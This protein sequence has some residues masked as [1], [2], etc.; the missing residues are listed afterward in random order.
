M[1]RRGIPWAGSELVSGHTMESKF[2]MSS[3]VFCSGAG[4]TV[5][6]R[7]VCE[8]ECAGELNHRSRGQWHM[9][10]FAWFSW[11]PPPESSAAGAGIGNVGCELI[12]GSAQPRSWPSVQIDSEIHLEACCAMTA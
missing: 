1:V 2:G 4:V 9:C 5:G 10:S 3:F 12:L 11:F 7:H 8:G 6:T